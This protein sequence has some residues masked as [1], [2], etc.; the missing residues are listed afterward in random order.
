V[1]NGTEVLNGT[2]PLDPAD[3]LS[4]TGARYTVRET[5]DVPP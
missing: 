1:G 2:D 4:R 5:D 3:D